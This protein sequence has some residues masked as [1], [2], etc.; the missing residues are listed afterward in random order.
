MTRR[1]GVGA[2]VVA[3]LVGAALP[4]CDDAAASAAEDEPPRRERAATSTSERDA[5]PPGLDEETARRLSQL[6]YGD[7]SD[8]GVDARNQASGVV[9][10]DRLATAGGR[11]LLTAADRCQGRLLSPE[12]H[13]LHTW[14]L[15]DDFAE[16]NGA[17]FPAADEAAVFVMY[18]HLRL[19][20]RDWRGDLVWSVEQ[21]VHH[22]VWEGADGSLAVLVEQMREFELGIEGGPV[23]IM[24][25]GVARISRDGELQD[26]VWFGE[27]FL[28][29]IEA[30]KIK[31]MRRRVAEDP[32]LLEKHGTSVLDRFHSN[33]VVLLEHDVPGFGERGQALVSIRNIS[34]LAVIDLDA[35]RLVWEWGP[36][37]LDNQHHPSLLPDGRLLIFDNGRDRGWSRLVE[38]DPVSRTILWE[39][40]ELEGRPFHTP[41]RGSAQRLPNGNTAI[42][43]SNSGRVTE[44]T[45]DGRIA[46]EW[47]HPDVNAETGAR[48]V[49]Y[50]V[51]WLPAPWPPM[52]GD[53]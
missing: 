39:Q 1:A 17:V 30:R 8:D 41:I 19:E 29:R 31:R 2:W 13:V 12:G 6:G 18:N 33:G 52:P 11:W 21:P 28:D 22:D 50:R 49:I 35:H 4:A 25:N 16:S 20:K 7:W 10:H 42:I 47:L 24:D 38:L 37:E 34:M 27:L 5:L 23:P 40:R 32:S 15:P 44:A 36:G 48:H 45:P 51:P 9:R 43:V 53:E 14:D 46:W 26:V 3:A